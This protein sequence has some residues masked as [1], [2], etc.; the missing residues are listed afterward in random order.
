MRRGEQGGRRRDGAVTMGGLPDQ[1][2]DVDGKPVRSER[3]RRAG[4]TQS[5]R[6]GA[7]GARRLGSTGVS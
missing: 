4:S 1:S 5:R 3:R 6:E 2:G 7:R